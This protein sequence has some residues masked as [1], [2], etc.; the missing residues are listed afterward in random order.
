MTGDYEPCQCGHHRSRHRTTLGRFECSLMR[1]DATVC[2]CQEFRPVPLS[3]FYVHWNG[4]AWFV[5][6]GDYFKAQGGLT[7]KWGKAWKPVQAMSCEHARA[8]AAAGKL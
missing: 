7:A 2:S 5:K 1:D 6:E 4:A 3:L 8:L